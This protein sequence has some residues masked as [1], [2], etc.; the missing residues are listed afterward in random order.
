MLPYSGNSNLLPTQL[1]LSELIG[2]GIKTSETKCSEEIDLESPGD[3]SAPTM[4]GP[5]LDDPRNLISVLPGL[6]KPD[7]SGKLYASLLREL[8]PFNNT[9]RAQQ[10]GQ[11]RES[12]NI[13]K[14]T[15]VTEK[16]DLKDLFIN[17][18]I[19]TRNGGQL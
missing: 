6:T 2:R 5:S 17:S 18:R 3:R 13:K 14:E 12:Q 4:G 8:K 19:F 15:Q 10:A 1:G 11:E 7:Q 9:V 16:S